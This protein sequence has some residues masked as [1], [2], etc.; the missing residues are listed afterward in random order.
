MYSEYISSPDFHSTRHH[1]ADQ[2]KQT[3]CSEGE[4]TQSIR[5]LSSGL[6]WAAGLSGSAMSN[7]RVS[8]DGPQ[9]S[10]E[11]PVPTERRG[12]VGGA[13]RQQQVADRVGDR[14]IKKWRRMIGI[15]CADFQAFSEREP[16]ALTRRA[17]KGVPDPLR[18]VVW[19]LLSGGRELLL[20]N[21]G[22]YEK[23]MLYESSN[24]EL[25]IVRDLSR[26]YPSHVYYQQRQGPGQRSLYNV[27]KAYSVY[28]RQVSVCKEGEGTGF[29]LGTA[30]GVS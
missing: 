30:C 21:E 18:G 14:Q 5:S 8:L 23:L 26:T 28:N 3:C 1:V 29:S 7:L 25:E 6:C 9:A 22:V 12:G 11:S 2:V 4:C 15:S 27:L 24:A 10:A 17:R 20:Q 19:Q 13:R 16:A